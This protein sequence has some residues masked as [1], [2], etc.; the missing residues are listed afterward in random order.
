[1]DLIQLKI[2]KDNSSTKYIKIIRKFYS[3]LS[4][5]AIKEKIEKVILC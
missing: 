1:M 3:T 4:V 2:E 5:G